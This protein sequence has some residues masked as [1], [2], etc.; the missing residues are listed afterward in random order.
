M[1][2]IKIAPSANEITIKGNKMTTEFNGLRITYTMV[3]SIN[4]TYHKWLKDQ[5]SMAIALSSRDWQLRNLM[6]GLRT[7]DGRQLGT[8]E[9]TKLEA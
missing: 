9:V 6:E 7:S 2:T 5:L 1:K 8:L 3:G 4:K